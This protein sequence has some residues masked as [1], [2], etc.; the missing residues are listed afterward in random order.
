MLALLTVPLLAAGPLCAAPASKKAAR[1]SVI[2]GELPS[3]QVKYRQLMAAVAT[4]PDS[5]R[6]AQGVPG[7]GSHGTGTGVVSGL[8]MGRAHEFAYYEA[9][10]EEILAAR[11]RGQKG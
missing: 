2:A 6:R 9:H 5:M 11:R 4:L 8:D 1:A 3:A 10:R 7:T